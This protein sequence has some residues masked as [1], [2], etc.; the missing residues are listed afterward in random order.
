MGGLFKRLTT[1]VKDSFAGTVPLSSE[2][3]DHEERHNI[4]IHK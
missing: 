1:L 3:T 2:N 4:H